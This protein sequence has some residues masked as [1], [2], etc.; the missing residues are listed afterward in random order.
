[1]GPAGAART[2]REPKS[3]A[4]RMLLCRTC[5][6]ALCHDGRTCASCR[7]AD[8]AT[9]LVVPYSF[10]LLLQEMQAMGISWRLKI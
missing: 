10:K 3:D 5:G 4:Y 7:S 2:R 9:S 1:M 6:Q 8:G